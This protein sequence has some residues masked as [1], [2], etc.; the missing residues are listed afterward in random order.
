MIRWPPPPLPSR[1]T[2]RN[3][4]N[5]PYRLR[6]RNKNEVVPIKNYNVWR[7][8][9][10]LCTCVF[11]E[12]KLLAR[13]DRSGAY[14]GTYYILYIYRYRLHR[15]PVCVR[16]RFAYVYVYMCVYMCLF[17]FPI[18]VYYIIIYC[19]VVIS[20]TAHHLRYISISINI[21]IRYYIYIYS[22]YI[23]LKIWARYKPIRV[24]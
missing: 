1:R 10:L 22:R 24:L 5:S 16:P 17:C 15:V 11:V 12:N 7:G 13:P 2:Q 23:H 20:S 4:N 14:I 18:C 19:F 6:E 21:I 8:P 9:V 3:L